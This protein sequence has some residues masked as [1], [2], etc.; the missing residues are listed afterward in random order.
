[1]VTVLQVDMKIAFDT[2][3]YHPM[4][5]EIRK[6]TPDLFPQAAFFIRLGP[7][8]GISFTPKPWRTVTKIEVLGCPW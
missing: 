5:E 4:L 8:P 2:L 3:D 1:M 6:W 7:P